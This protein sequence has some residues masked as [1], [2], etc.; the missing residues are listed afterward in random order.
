MDWFEVLSI[1]IK[2]FFRTTGEYR[3]RK[4]STKYESEAKVDVRGDEDIGI[5]DDNDNDKDDNSS[6]E[7][8]NESGESYEDMISILP[9]EP[10]ILKRMKMNVVFYQLTLLRATQTLAQLSNWTS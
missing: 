2:G 6:L 5:E 9:S 7:I 1:N 10:V 4:V 8:R 3:V